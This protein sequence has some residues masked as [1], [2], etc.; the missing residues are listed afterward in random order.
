MLIFVQVQ[1]KTK[2]LTKGTHRIFQDI[3]ITLHFVQNLSLS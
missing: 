3:V 1:E 2:I